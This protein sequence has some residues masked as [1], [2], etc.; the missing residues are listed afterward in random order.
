M[1]I[2]LLGPPGVGKGTQAERLS[3]KY[4]RPQVATGDI[5]RAAVS[6]GTPLGVEAKKYMDSGEL[7]PDSVV[8]GIVMQRLSAEDVGDGFLLDGFPRNT[9]QA[10]ALDAFLEKEGRPLDL[11]LNMVADPGVLVKRIAGRR[12]CSGCGANF[13]VETMPPAAEGV[14]DECGGELYQREDDN[15]ETVKKRLEVY[16]LQTEPLIRYYEPSGRMVTVD[17]AGDREGVLADMVAA[18]EKA[19]SGGVG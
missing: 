15:E 14:C 1:N 12:V 4:G 16:R 2:V 8:E 9:H 5:F 11:V 17:G 10:E 7:V 3:G 18:V 6:E 19:R 13:H